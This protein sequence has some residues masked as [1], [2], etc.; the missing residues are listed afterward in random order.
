MSADL[1]RIA[2]EWVTEQ[3]RRATMRVWLLLG[4][5]GVALL[6]GALAAQLGWLSSREGAGAGLGLC[7][8]ALLAFQAAEQ[9]SLEAMA[10]IRGSRAEREVGAELDLLRADGAFVIHDV[11]TGRGNIDHVVGLPRGA[12]VVETKYR[13]YEERHLK[14]AK[15]NAHWLHERVGLWVTPVICLASRSDRPYRRDGVWVMGKPHLN[16]WLRGRR[17]R[18][19]DVE[20][21]RQALRV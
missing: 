6:G 20:R 19:I 5:F 9:R 15:R 4:L 1:N 17:G 8:L 11:D 13:R 14:Q 10:W 2:G 18:S 3:S 7:A 21:L 12:Y 16:S